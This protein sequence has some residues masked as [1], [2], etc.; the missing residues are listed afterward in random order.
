MS[1]PSAWSLF[2]G[3]V[4]FFMFVCVEEVVSRAYFFKILEYT[5]VK[6]SIPII[7]L[8]NRLRRVPFES[9]LS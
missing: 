2:I 5:Q 1:L 7:E 4:L 6:K 3:F 9:H 8:S